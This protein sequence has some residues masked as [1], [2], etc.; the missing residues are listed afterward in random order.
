MRKRW[1][2]LA[3]AGIIASVAG[4]G[5]QPHVVVTGVQGGSS[6][7]KIAN[8]ESLVPAVSSVGPSP[9]SGLAGVSVLDLTWVSD[10]RG[11]ALTAVPCRPGLC[12]RVAATT[13]GGRTWRALP[14][15]PGLIQSGTTDCTHL[16]C[17]SQVRFATA[18]VGYLFGPA[19]FQTSDGGRTWRRVPSSPVEALE[20]AAG[21]VIRVVY[22]YTG[23]PGPCTRTVQEAAAGQSTWRT[24]L[25]I[26]PGMGDSRDVLAQVIRL[27]AAV[28]YVPVYGDLAA[29]VGSQHTVIFRSADG[30]TTWRRLADP[31]GGAGPTVRDTVGLA[32]APGGFVAALCVPRTVTGPKSVVTSGDNGLSWSAPRPVPGSGRYF[33][34][35]IAAASPDRLVVATGDAGGGP[36]ALFV[37]TDGGRRWS[38]AVSGTAPGNPQGLSASFLTLEDLRVGWWISDPRDMWTTSDGGLHW[39]RQAS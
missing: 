13:D 30:G 19:L 8:A 38:T 37:S 6:V 33:L 29:G 11:W 36:L 16:A 17:V 35:L 5:G 14:A 22:D 20:P 39:R 28:S 12:P 27:G 7:S 25:R 23:C 15:P 32:A 18:T 9:G 24:L 10:E 2:L 1:L 3:T 26:T 21:T 31:C 4:C 34:N